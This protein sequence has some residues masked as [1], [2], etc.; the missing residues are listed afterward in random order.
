MTPYYPYERCVISNSSTPTLYPCDVYDHCA[1]RRPRLTDPK[2]KVNATIVSISA[3]EPLIEPQ[4]TTLERSHASFAL[5]AAHEARL[6]LSCRMLDTGVASDVS[7]VLRI[8]RGG[9]WEED[10]GEGGDEDGEAEGE[11]EGHEYLYHVGSDWGVKV[12]ERGQG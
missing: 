2:Q 7:G 6:V 4:N 5:A 12:F 11:V 3:D 1:R 9:G 10:V 8:A